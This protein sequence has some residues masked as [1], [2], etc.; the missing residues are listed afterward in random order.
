MNSRIV[1]ATINAR[2]Q[3]AAFGLRYLYANLGALREMTQI[4]EWSLGVRERDVVEQL[5]ALE[6]EIIGFS[7]YI[8]NVDEIT[9]VV[10]M[11]KRLSP[12]TVVVVGGPEVSF[13]WEETPL[14]DEADYLVRG[15]GEV[16]FAKLCGEVLAG[17]R[18]AEK[19]FGGGL[20]ELSELR[21]PYPHYSDFDLKH[22]R[23]VYVEASRGCP[24]QCHFCLSS[25]DK[26]VRAFPLDEF[27]E[28]M[29]LLMSRGVL[30]FKF[31][32]RTFN[33]KQATSNRILSFFLERYREGMFLH[34][35]MIPDRLPEELR[36]VIAAFPPGVLQF[37]V[38]IQ[39]FNLGAR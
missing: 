2:F 32:D 23:I 20:P 28:Q 10:Q 11:L 13:E 7:V 24:F 4:Q 26:Q 33:L 14:F 8:W 15:E 21:W 39:S 27:L 31:V 25:L 34:F 12:Q 29:E 16:A 5:V 17:R 3:H 36:P 35:E 38:G 18:P 9:R 6:P 37:E 22:G 19:V 30:R 1:L